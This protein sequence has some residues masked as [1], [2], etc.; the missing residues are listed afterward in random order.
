MEGQLFT[1]MISLGVDIQLSK[2]Q[3]VFN[4][5]DKMNQSQAFGVKIDLLIKTLKKLCLD[6]ILTTL[7]ICID[8]KQRQFMAK[9]QDKLEGRL[10]ILR[11]EDIDN[12][13]LDQKILKEIEILMMEM[14]FIMIKSLTNKENHIKLNETK[15]SISSI[16]DL[17]NELEILYDMIDDFELPNLDAIIK[18]LLID[19]LVALDIGIKKE[20]KPYVT[21]ISDTFNEYIQD[22]ASIL[23][24]SL[25][26][27][28]DLSQSV[29]KS[30]SQSIAKP[31]IFKQEISV[32][33]DFDQDIQNIIDGYYNQS[34]AS[35]KQRN[36]ESR[37]F[38]QFTIISQTQKSEDHL[39]SFSQFDDSN[40][41][42]PSQA[43][44]LQLTHNPSSFNPSLQNTALNAYNNQNP[45]FNT[46][47]SPFNIPM[48]QLKKRD[49][50]LSQKLHAK[51]K[52]QK[53]IKTKKTTSII[54]QSTQSMMAGKPI[55]MNQGN[56]IKA[57]NANTSTLNSNKN[58]T[59]GKSGSGFISNLIRSRCQVLQQEEQLQQKQKTEEQKQVEV[60][61]ILDSDNE[62]CSEEILFLD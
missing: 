13:E 51:L 12:L 57:T 38:N 54:T 23:L 19:P 29:V 3:L 17:A 15:V 8:N 56:V 2:M 26:Q 39:P 43:S 37:N 47:I 20:L 49:E 61:E 21:L 6:H 58:V 60:I 53:I 22:S 44:Q 7:K 32:Q 27:S 1:D 55:N 14:H 50:K 9:L 4:K 59:G 35:F 11:N 16:E 52:E 10:L 40:F 25:D 18:K 24:N 34:P 48:S 41:K 36:S 42:I 30:Q 45:S 28:E 46:N 62:L 5:M 33:T 31:K